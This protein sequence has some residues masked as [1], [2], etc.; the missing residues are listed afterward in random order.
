MNKLVDIRCYF[1]HI[2][3]PF[4]MMTHSNIMCACMIY[5]RMEL[6]LL[7]GLFSSLRLMRLG[8]L[9]HGAMFSNLDESR[10][11]GQIRAFRRLGKVSAEQKW[12][13]ST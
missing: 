2:W 3:I 1:I 4:G 5:E 7:V 9:Q 8:I 13:L 6:R 10:L 12:K 11:L